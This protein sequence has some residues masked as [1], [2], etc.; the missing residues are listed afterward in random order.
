MYTVHKFA[1]KPSY[2]FMRVIFPYTFS[3]KFTKTRVLTLHS[4]INMSF[5]HRF[6][7]VALIAVGLNAPWK[8][9]RGRKHQ[10]WIF[11]VAP[12]MRDMPSGSD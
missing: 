7:G 4:C 3:C 8:W 2:T 5:S 1:C 12:E 10:P 6:F 9:G 11:W